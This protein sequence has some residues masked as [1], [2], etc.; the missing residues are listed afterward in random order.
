[1]GSHLLSVLEAEVSLM[2]NKWQKHPIVANLE[3]PHIL[4]TIPK[5]YF[6]D[7][8]G[9]ECAFGIA[10]VGANKNKQLP[11]SSSLE[12]DPSVAG[13]LHGK[14]QSGYQWPPRWCTS[15]TPPRLPESHPGA[16]SL[17]HSSFPVLY[18]Q[19]KSLIE[20]GG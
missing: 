15:I 10:A 13:L 11:T 19:C 1:M 18:G 9:Y 3:A 4:G 5:G 16:D 20:A 2:G 8:K 14:N 6:K 7:P 17:T 12:K